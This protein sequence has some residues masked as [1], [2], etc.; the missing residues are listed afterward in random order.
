ML[1]IGTPPT[2]HQGIES[3]VAAFILQPQITGAPPGYDIAILPEDVNNPRR[4]QVTLD[5]LVGSTQRATILLNE[6][7][8]PSTRA[9]FA[10][11]FDAEAR[12]PVDPPAADLIFPIPGVTAGTYLVR[13]RIDGAESP[14]DYVD[15]TG[16]VSPVVNL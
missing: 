6:I 15:P 7:N 8:A 14:L 4:L 1:Q 11:T 5:P 3:N 10:F 13:V 12:D 16:Y 9:P 2:T